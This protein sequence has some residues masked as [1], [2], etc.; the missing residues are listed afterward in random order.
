[1]SRENAETV[2]RWLDAFGH[3]DFDAALALVH[4]DVVLAPPGD[5]ALHTGAESLRRWMEPDA[6]PTQAIEVL[7][8]VPGPDRRI[9]ARHHVSARGRASGIELDMISWSV[10]T[11]DED[12]LVTRIE[13]YLDRE[14]D[15]ALEAAGL[16][17]SALDDER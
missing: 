1:V 4:P 3:E 12:G 7:D 8:T 10:W 11:F 16:S 9:L 17:G 5:Q 6:F 14:R 15:Q 2:R 13:I